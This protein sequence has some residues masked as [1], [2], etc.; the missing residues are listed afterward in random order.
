MSTPNIRWAKEACDLKP[1]P[2]SGAAITRLS[3]SAAFTHNIYCCE[4]TASR[5]GTRIAAMRYL[6]TFMNAML[7]GIDLTTKYT[8]L[9]EREMTGWP[10]G[11]AWGG[12]I[13]YPSGTKLMRASLD[14]MQVKPVLDFTGMPRCWQL[15]S[16]SSDERHML[17]T[18]VV[19]E[20]PET[21][22]VVR[23][24]LQ[25]LKWR[26]L[27]DESTTER[28][29]AVF[30]PVTSDEILIGKTFWEGKLRFGRNLLA[31]GDGKIIRELFSRVHHSVWVGDG[32]AVAALHEM[33]YE[34]LVHL[35]KYP[36]GEL[37]IYPKDGSA[38]RLIPAREHLLYHVSSSRCGRYLVFEGIENILKEGPVPIVVFGVKSGKYRTLVANCGCRG[39]GGGNDS[40]QAKPYFTADNRYVIYTAD[41][42]G[43]VNVYSAEVP[44]GFLESLDQETRL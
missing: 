27:C 11:P 19:G 28:I 35:P 32:S 16:F 36:D 5:D 38:P 26:L 21:Y 1:D 34:K 37:V 30:S 12:S 33:D 20:D 8:C 25:T 15:M 18:G 24:D 29:G 17:Y 43:I 42:D 41:P 4:P 13:Y 10:V 31:D 22:N 14:D 9:I 40:R 44:A 3:G 2:V 39:G 23:V 7:V 6:D